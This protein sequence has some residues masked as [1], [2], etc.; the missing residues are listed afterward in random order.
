MKDKLRFREIP[1]RLPRGGWAWTVVA[2]LAAV[3]G[4]ACGGDERVAVEAL[5][6]GDGWTVLDGGAGGSDGGAGGGD[7]GRVVLDGGGTPITPPDGGAVPAA[8]ISPLA[9]TLGQLR[10]LAVD[11]A[12]AF[13]L[14][15]GASGQVVSCPAAGCAATTLVRSALAAPIYGTATLDAFGGRVYFSEGAQLRRASADGS[16]LQSIPTGGTLFVASPVTPTGTDFY[17]Q[18]QPAS[19]PGAPANPPTF[20]LFS[21]ATLAAG[22]PVSLAVTGEAQLVVEGNRRFAA[23]IAAVGPFVGVD[24]QT[25]ATWSTPN[26]KVK[27]HGVGA[28]LNHVFFIDA[29]SSTLRVCPA[30]TPCPSPSVVLAGSTFE[31]LRIDGADLVLATK[32]NGV[33]RCK[34]ADVA[35]GAACPALSY[36]AT[37]TAGTTFVGFQM[38]ASG[39]FFLRGTAGG[40][41]ELV[42]LPR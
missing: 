19:G 12:T 17:V 39:Y 10:A 9:A 26:T 33:H 16:N 15:G 8:S 40:G 5:D 20:R 28:T 32:E 6:A 35:A 2:G 24:V 29:A 11:D 13:I 34:A 31:E 1:R 18:V 41:G 25:N 4:G 3:A 22:T 7:G 42:R 37:P 36:A 30:A 14:A 27:R 23:P 38:T 21:Q